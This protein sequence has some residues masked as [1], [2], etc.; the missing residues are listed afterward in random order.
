MVD[1]VLI[2]HVMFYV[3]VISNGVLIEL[4]MLPNNSQEKIITF[5]IA[6]SEKVFCFTSQ[7]AGSAYVI[8][9]KDIT[10]TSCK[11]TN[12]QG[13]VEGVLMCIGI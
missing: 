3:L 6:Y 5:P 7:Y 8:F 13:V 12:Y 2:Y 11:V 9:T 4:F 1:M 10:L